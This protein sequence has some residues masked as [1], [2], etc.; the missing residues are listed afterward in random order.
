MF[1]KSRKKANRLFTEFLNKQ[2][3]SK[4]KINYGDINSAVLGSL[5][6]QILSHKK[7]IEDFSSHLKFKKKNASGRVNFFVRRKNPVVK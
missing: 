1:L 3:I 7:L 4:N 2:S 5:R 6:Q